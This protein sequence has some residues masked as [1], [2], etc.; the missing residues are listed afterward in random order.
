MGCFHSP[1]LVSSARHGDVT[2]ALILL[3]FLLFL[4]VFTLLSVKVL[5]CGL[6]FGEENKWTW[7]IGREGRLGPGSSPMKEVHSATSSR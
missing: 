6:Q 7:W 4:S 2:G 1:V 3:L 5:Q